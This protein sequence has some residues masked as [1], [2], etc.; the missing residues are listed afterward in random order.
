MSQFRRIRFVIKVKNSGWLKASKGKLVG[1][2]CK[3]NSVLIREIIKS[4]KSLTRSCIMLKHCSKLLGKCWMSIRKKCLFICLFVENEYNQIDKDAFDLHETRAPHA[5]PMFVCQG[6]SFYMY[7][8]FY[9]KWTQLQN[10][11]FQRYAPFCNCT[12]SWWASIP[13]LVLTFI[14]F[15]SNGLY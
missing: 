15:L 8:F 1:E 14:T 9:L 3:L 11:T 6:P 10:Y 5:V 4:A 7:L 13:S 12:F 2:K